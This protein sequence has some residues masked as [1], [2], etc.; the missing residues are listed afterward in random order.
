ME[1]NIQ[2]L[3][4]GT[5]CGRKHL[6]LVRPP[7][8]VKV[9]EEGL[10]PEIPPSQ[11][12]KQGDIAECQFC[13]KHEKIDNMTYQLC[14]S[15]RNELQYHGEKCIKEADNG[16]VSIK[17]NLIHKSQGLCAIRVIT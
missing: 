17:L 5:I 7:T 3:F 1:R 16:K 13:Y 4:M 6:H 8:F 2:Q 11:R 10:F 12:V 15:C 9:K 14:S